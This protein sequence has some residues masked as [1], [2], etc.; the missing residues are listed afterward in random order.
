MIADNVPTRRE[1]CRGIVRWCVFQDSCRTV[2]YGCP[3]AERWNPVRK[4]QGISTRSSFALSRQ[5]TF[6]ALELRENLLH[7]SVGQVSRLARS[8]NLLFPPF[9]IRDVGFDRLRCKIR[10]RPRLVLCE[11]FEPRFGLG[12]EANADCC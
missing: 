5:R 6:K 11:L 8:R 3:L 7:L 9:L 12:A 2:E 4:C 10:S 1:S